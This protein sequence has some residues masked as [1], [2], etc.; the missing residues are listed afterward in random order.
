MNYSLI[1]EISNQ[2]N[3]FESTYFKYSFKKAKFEYSLTNKNASMIMP[4]FHIK[5]QMT[6]KNQSNKMPYFYIYN[7]K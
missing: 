2:L 5:H 3:A 7:A 1:F 4:S 6:K